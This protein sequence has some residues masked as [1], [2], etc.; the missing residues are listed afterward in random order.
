MHTVINLCKFELNW[1]SKLRDNV[2]QEKTPL[3]H[4]VECFQLLD[5][6][7]AKFNFEFWK[8]NSNIVE[9]Y[10]FL[11]NYVSSEGVVSLNVLNYQQLSNCL[12]PSKF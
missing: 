6:G 8:S 7:T 4:K 1:L 2:M 9:S 11:E 3:P 10:L 12:L 5:F